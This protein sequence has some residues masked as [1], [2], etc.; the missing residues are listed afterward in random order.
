MKESSVK[1]IQGSVRMEHLC[2]SLN[3]KGVEGEQS[4]LMELVEKYSELFALSS[5]ELGC[6]SL[7]EH[8]INTGDHPPIKQLPRRVPHFL[9]TKV[10]Q[11]VQEMLKQGVVTPSHSPWASPVVLVAKKDGTTRF[12]M[13]Y[14]K[15]NAVTKMDVHP[16]PR[17]DDSLDQLAG[18]CYFSTLD[19]ASGYWQVGMHEESQE[20][21]AF[22]T[23]NG[24]YEFKVMPFGLCNA[25][26]MFQRLMEKVLSGAVREKCL[27][28]LDDILV[29]GQT[30]QFEDGV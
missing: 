16:L 22:V 20:K 15:L 11:H 6:T 24:L 23:W 14:R 25:P 3:I 17:I 9:K 7:I 27:I 29:M 28:Y 19:L 1:A 13:D 2:E 18:S 4:K 12:C 5:T 26:A 8:S 10:S 30:H 21:T